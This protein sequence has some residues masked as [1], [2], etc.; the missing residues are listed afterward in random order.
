MT[1]TVPRR[2]K[3]ANEIA[4]EIEWKRRDFDEVEAKS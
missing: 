4:I 3:S 1:M 2:E